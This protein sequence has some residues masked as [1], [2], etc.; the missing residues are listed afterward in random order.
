MD[1]SNCIKAT[2][3]TWTL[4]KYTAYPENK[5]HSL[6]TKK[7]IQHLLFPIFGICVYEWAKGALKKFTLSPRSCAYNGKYLY[8]GK[9]QWKHTL[10][11][12]KHI[13]GV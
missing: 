9:A 8:K 3:L 5:R 7:I 11:M 12:I 2:K 13:L 1:A 10:G 6:K 4:L